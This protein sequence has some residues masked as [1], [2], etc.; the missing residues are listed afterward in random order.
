MT[1][2]AQPGQRR[3]TNENR[4]VRSVS[5]RPVTEL[6]RRTDER[7]DQP[8]AARRAGDRPRQAERRCQKTVTTTEKT[9]L[10]GCSTRRLPHL[11]SD[12]DI[13]VPRPNAAGPRSEPLI[14]G[15]IRTSAVDI[16]ER[17]NEPAQIAFPHP[18]AQMQLAPAGIRSSGT[19]GG[20]RSGCSGSA[21]AT[22]KV[23][24]VRRQLSWRGEGSTNSP[25]WAQRIFIS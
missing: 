7:S 18:N 22:A 1:P 13:N 17:P 10:R 5:A 24:P 23:R 6:G 20:G 19:S 2:R 4:Y 9:L 12:L 11:R 3:T 21:L 15:R 16:G 8:S 14:L 25:Q